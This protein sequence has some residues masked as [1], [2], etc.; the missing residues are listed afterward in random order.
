MRSNINEASPVQ[1]E[2]PGIKY[3]C[4]NM[5]HLKAI[6]EGEMVDGFSYSRKKLV[7]K[8]TPK[9]IECKPKFPFSS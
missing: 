4:M 2:G 6:E 3:K 8:K 5:S 9:L 7:L 1:S